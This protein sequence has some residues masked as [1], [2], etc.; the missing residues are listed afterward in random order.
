MFFT[1][2]LSWRRLILIGGI[3]AAADVCADMLRAEQYEMKQTYAHPGIRIRSNRVANWYVLGEEVVFSPE[4]P[5]PGSGTVTVTLRT[6]D[7]SVFLTR[8]LPLSE[9]NTRGWRWK[10]EE[11]G[12][13]NVRFTLGGKALGDGW[14]APIWKLNPKKNR[15]EE[16]ARCSYR[17]ADHSLGVVEEKARVPAEMSPQ[18][19]LCAYLNDK[20]LTMARYVGFRGLRIGDLDWEKIAPEKGKFQW[21]E[22][23]SKIALAEQYGFRQEDMLF[24]LIGVP[25]WAS[26]RPDSNRLLLGSLKEYRTVVPKDLNDWADYLRALIRHFPKVRTYELWNEPHFPGYS[27]FWSDTPEN[28]VRLMESG[29]RAIKG[30]NPAIRVWWAGISKRYMTFYQRILE[31]GGGQF[32]D[33]LSLHGTWQSY[34]SFSALEKKA[35]LPPKPKANSEWHANLIK[36]WQA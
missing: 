7:E 32:F 26:S 31:L 21:K 8:T 24:T 34:S 25:R 9:F 2:K 30:E 15:Y 10:S 4:K 36:P 33:V 23:D 11:A 22:I 17:R 16:V 6:G 3:C 35:G 19:N 13:Y 28:H 27:I 14:T 18:F 20:E 1:G 5:I 29:Y 12:F